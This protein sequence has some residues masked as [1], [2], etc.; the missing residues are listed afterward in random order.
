[1]HARTVLGVRKWEVLSFQI[2]SLVPLK[3]W[4]ECSV[5]QKKEGKWGLELPYRVHVAASIRRLQGHGTIRLLRDILLISPVASWGSGGK[6]R[7]KVQWVRNSRRSD[8]VTNKFLHSCYQLPRCSSQTTNVSNM[9]AYETRPRPL[10]SLVIGQCMSDHM[11]LRNKGSLT[12]FQSPEMVILGKRVTCRHP[13]GRICR[14][15]HSVSTH[16]L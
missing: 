10:K 16:T 3:R 5:T 9:T 13:P 15:S 2:V 6:M 14:W 7:S 1:M 12:L 11:V 8:L 4:G